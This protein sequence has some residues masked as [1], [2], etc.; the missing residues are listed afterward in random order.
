MKN[1]YIYIAAVFLATSC[2]GQEKEKTVSNNSIEISNKEKG[3]SKI[4]FIDYP[5]DDL[6]GITSTQFEGIYRNFDF[7]YS[8]G[9]V[10]FILIPKM[11]SEKWYKQQANIYKNRDLDLSIE[12]KLNNDSFKNLSKE[13]EIWVFHTPKKYLKR[14]PN[15]DSPY[16]LLIPRKIFLYQYNSSENKWIETDHFI[17]NN[18]SDEAKAN[19]WR[20]NIISNFV[21]HSDNISLRYLK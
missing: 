19:H 8:D 16:S 1:K 18:G 3:V 7:K 17:V 9:E 10:T 14:T 12:T 5:I 11:S 20:E 2:N 15:M 6:E 21:I 4:N 13:F